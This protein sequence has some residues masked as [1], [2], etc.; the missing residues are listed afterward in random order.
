MDSVMG[1]FLVFVSGIFV[2]WDPDV[3]PLW[4]Q[5]YNIY[6][7]SGENVTFPPVS[8]DIVLLGG[9]RRIWLHIAGT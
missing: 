5:G 3:F 7:S 9:L 2:V 4:S 1:P 8:T 6:F